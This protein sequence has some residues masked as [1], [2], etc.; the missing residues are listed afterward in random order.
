MEVLGIRSIP[1]AILPSGQDMET[2][3]SLI[4]YIHDYSWVVKIRNTSKAIYS[5]NN[6]PLS[7]HTDHGPT[8]L[9]Q[10]NSVYVEEYWGSYTVSS[11]FL[12]MHKELFQRQFF[13]IFRANFRALNHTRTKIRAGWRVLSNR[14][15]SKKHS[16]LGEMKLVCLV[17]IFSN[18]KSFRLKSLHQIFYSDMFCRIY[19]LR[20]DNSGWPPYE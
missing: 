18:L 7:H 2:I 19:S 12:N 20:I 16:L 5:S 11:V 14:Q 13:S 10:Y 17:Q 4:A 6:A 3:A 15:V 1:V 9:G 8:C